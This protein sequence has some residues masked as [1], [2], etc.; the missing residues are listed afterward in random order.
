MSIFTYILL[1]SFFPVVNDD[2]F[3]VSVV[4]SVGDFV[5]AA[6]GFA[7]AVVAVVVSVVGVLVTFLMMTMMLILRER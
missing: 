2:D 3:A 5:D 6:D 7:L 1:F 4:V